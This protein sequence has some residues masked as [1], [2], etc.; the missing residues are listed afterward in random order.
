MADPQLKARVETSGRAALR[1][2]LM[3]GGGNFFRIVEVPV[4]LGC[5]KM[6]VR[7]GETETNTEGLLRLG[8]K[9]LVESG[10]REK[11]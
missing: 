8:L 4:F 1:W 2:L 10:N 7:L 11:G 5:D 9:M 6:E 3:L